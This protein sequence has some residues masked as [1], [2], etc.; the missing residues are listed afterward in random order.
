[1]SLLSRLKPRG[2][3]GFGY[4][5][6]VD[7]VTAG[8]DLAGRTILITG[9]RSGLGFQ[10]ARGL[11]Q[12]G[13]RII[14]CARSEELAAAA[15]SGGP[16]Q[17]RAVACDL[18]DVASIRRCIATVKAD[19]AERGRALDA[20]VCNAGVMALP[21]LRQAY[22]IELQFFTN[23]LGHF[24]LVNGLLNQLAP[25]GRVV[26]VSSAAHRRAPRAGIEFDNLSGEKRYR[27]WVAYG[28]S[29]LAN[30]LFSN[31]LARRLAGT[32]KTANALHP[33]VIETPLHRH[34]SAPERLGLAVFGPLIFKTPAQGAATQS[35]LAV[36][37][38]AATLSG[39]Y[40]KDCNPA[41]PTTLGRDAS[42]ARKLWDE[43][44]LILSRL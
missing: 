10:T 41:T 29:K 16:G 2:P 20:L 25:R 1:M 17:H 44:E 37:P 21:T 19:V 40:F 28:Q 43:S 31:E 11:A 5:S 32:E 27:P 30:L 26:V 36:H 38:G 33:G 42:L 15:L 22:G 18:A 14:G 6:T 3:N 13:A 8:L 35:Y 4:G 12:R 39:G 7:D 24:L 34:L 23:H 9:V